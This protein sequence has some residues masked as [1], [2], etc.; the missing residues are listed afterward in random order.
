MIAW[1]MAAASAAPVLQ[2]AD[3][4]LQRCIDSAAA[5][6]DGVPFEASALPLRADRVA[7][8][9]GVPCHRSEG[10]PSL[11]Y[12]SRDAARVADT[13]QRSGY[14]VIRLV[15]L[16][17]RSAFSAALDRAEAMVSPG[18]TLVVY[19]SGHGVLREQSGRLSRYLVFSDTELGAVRTT[20]LSV[21]SLDDRISRIGAKTRVVIQDTCFAAH[22]GGKSL[23]L[24]GLTEGRNKGV[25]LPEPRL[26][27]LDEDIRLYASR[28]FELALESPEHRGSLY[29]HHLLA[30]L[31]ASEADL[32]GDGCVGLLEGH[33]WARRQ[34]SLERDG[35]QTPQGQF[36]K[37]H[38]P[39]LACTPKAPVRGVLQIP[40]DDAWSVE[41]RA[42]DGT[43]VQRS[44]GAVPAGRY[45]VHVDRLE[46]TEWGELSRIELFDASLRVAAGQWID[47]ESEITERH[48][49]LATVGLD[50]GWRGPGDLPSLSAGV[51][52]WYSGT[53]RRIGRT[54]FGI[55]GA[56]GAGPVQR[57]SCGIVRSTEAMGLIGQLWSVESRGST[58]SVG[59]VAGVGVALQS[60]ENICTEG[61]ARRTLPANT[62]TTAIRVQWHVADT[63]VL[64]L[65]GG[66]HG[67][68]VESFGKPTLETRPALHIGVGPTL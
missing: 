30:A 17:D 47:L 62:G 64:S 51:S 43:V 39:L 22:P 35:F 55:R 26:E 36:L 33:L 42:R 21:L 31:E 44:G 29:T 32:D 16:V 60:R 7:V 11:A 5:E 9:V 57:D 34:T 2:Q 38:N 8:V 45:Q 65:E 27:L 19:F 68:L 49:P 59:P 12:S 4:P 54:T 24:S 63:I 13:L 14:A 58:W 66:L 6:S 28:F 25:G 41:V 56:L 20:G 10:I 18:G 1:L 37:P 46:E 23:G 15:D 3:D 61:V 50:A 48:T 67:M 52:A 53:A 40:E